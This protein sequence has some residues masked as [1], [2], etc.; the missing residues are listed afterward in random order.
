MSPMP[1]LSA[2]GQFPG[3]N[4]EGQ[5]QGDHGDSSQLR[6]QNPEFW[7]LK[8]AGI[9]GVELQRA[10]QREGPEVFVGASQECAAEGQAVHAQGQT[11]QG[12][13]ERSWQEIESKREKSEGEDYR[14]C[15][16]SIPVR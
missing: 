12:L 1:W 10:M 5:N 6:K 14:H 11:N 8:A 16:N 15:Q 9:R 13:S 2:W 7:V 4:A 3:H